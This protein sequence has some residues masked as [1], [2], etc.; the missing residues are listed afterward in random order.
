ME[1]VRQTKERLKNET[2]AKVEKERERQKARS[3]MTDNKLEDAK[4]EAQREHQIALRE[5]KRIAEKT[6]R[7]QIREQRE[8]YE[9][10]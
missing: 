4:E 7:D 5:K 6:Y 1:L 10:E 8:K 2:K 3:A 9:E